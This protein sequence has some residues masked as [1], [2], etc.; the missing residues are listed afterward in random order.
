MTL[1]RGTE[2]A[3]LAPNDRVV[4]IENTSEL[5]CTLPNHVQLLGTARIF[6]GGVAVVNTHTCCP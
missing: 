6:T 1:L 5:N 2:W 3:A 4:I